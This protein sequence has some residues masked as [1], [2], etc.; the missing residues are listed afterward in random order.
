MAAGGGLL[1][2]IPFLQQI[3][4]PLCSVETD[5]LVSGTPQQQQQLLAKCTWQVGGLQCIRTIAIDPAQVPAYPLLSSG[6][7]F[8]TISRETLFRLHWLCEQGQVNVTRGSIGTTTASIAAFLAATDPQ[9][10]ALRVTWNRRHGL[11]RFYADHSE[12]RNIGSAVGGLIN[13]NRTVRNAALE[14]HG[15]IDIDQEKSYPTLLL[16]TARLCG[17]HTPALQSYVDNSAIFRQGVIDFW[18]ADP[19]NPITTDDAKVLILRLLYGGG[20]AGWLTFL[21]DGRDPDE[22]RVTDPKPL[23]N[24]AQ[25]PE[26]V[27]ELKK[28]CDLMIKLIYHNNPGIKDCVYQPPPQKRGQ[29]AP[30]APCEWSLSRKVASYFFQTLENHFTYAAL[31][32]LLRENAIVQERFVWGYDGISWV[33]PP[34][35]NIE[36]LVEGLNVHVASI[37]GNAFPAVRFSLKD[38]V[39][40]LPSVCNDQH[41]YWQDPAFLEGLIAAHAGTKKR[42][43]QEEVAMDRTYIEMKRFFERDHFKVEQ[44]SARYVRTF[45]DE[46]GLLT[47]VNFLTGA[48]LVETYRQWSYIPGDEQFITAWMKDKNLRLKSRTVTIPPPRT[49]DE[50]NE[51]NLW[52]FSPYHMR[53]PR[54]TVYSAVQQEVIDAWCDLNRIICGTGHLGPETEYTQFWIA[55]MLQHPG[56]KL[57]VMLC[58]QGSEGIGKSLFGSFICELVGSERAIVMELEDIISSFNNMLDGKLFVQID[59]LER[60]KRGADGSGSGLATMKK[61]ITDKKYIS[62]AKYAQPKEEESFH[63]FLST[64][65]NPAVID[66]GRRP[67]YCLGSGELLGHSENAVRKRNLFWGLLD[68]PDRD[69]KMHRFSGLYHY[70]YFMDLVERF[71]STRM[72]P[73]DNEL[74]REQKKGRS[75]ASLFGDWL[76]NTQFKL[77]PSAELTGAELHSHYVSYCESTNTAA[78]L[79]AHQLMNM[80]IRAASWPEGAISASVE[81][82]REGAP[83]RIRKYDFVLMRQCLHDM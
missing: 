42:L 4:R 51:F 58:L 50:D 77:V 31:E 79:N 81:I 21:R 19:Q 38:I 56:E 10:D 20:V 48:E 24:Q 8:E 6:P 33:P 34:G 9:D 75:M 82:Y 29:P 30:P 54:N 1:H 66:S 25:C 36:A 28:E 64:S 72:S 15:Y 44:P 62:N 32:F 55:Q 59:E 18:S 5:I 12:R 69:R 35:T 26:N 39:H 37:T 57:G 11:G 61:M 68:D 16:E 7:V 45:H 63:R 76:A 60:V 43:R 83:V 41:E 73:P 53:L 71:G 22:D 52:T 47:K 13:L 78:E 27:R 17:I 70:F 74:N 23:R 3:T 67:F 14:R 40:D 80:F 49:Y 2:N 65:N 46:R